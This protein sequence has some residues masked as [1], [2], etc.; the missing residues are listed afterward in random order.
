M[1]PV[2][3][4][5]IGVGA[6]LLGLGLFFFVR[7]RSFLSRAVSVTGAV[8]GFRESRGSE[9]GTVYQPVVT[10]RTTEGQTHEFTD[11]VASD[12]PGFT[13]GEAVPVAYDPT[14]PEQAK[15]ARPFRLWFVSG[16]LSSM[17]ALFLVLGVVLAVAL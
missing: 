11:S 17:G 8:I 3:P 13:V 14:D 2:G 16:L 6:L 1:N 9:G 4:I 12:P 15:I 10:Y 7:T 5:F